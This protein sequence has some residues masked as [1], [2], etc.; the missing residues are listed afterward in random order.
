MY[1]YDILGD[2]AL[3]GLCLAQHLAPTLCCSSWG[4][5]S[6]KNKI[7]PPAK[8]CLFLTRDF[9]IFTFSQQQHDPI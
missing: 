2:S 8:S 3:R 9:H 5:T 1:V 7:L 6:R 4:P